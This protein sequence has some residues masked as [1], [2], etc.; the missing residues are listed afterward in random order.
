MGPI[1]GSAFDYN[2]AYDGS[3]DAGYNITAPGSAH[4]GSTASEMAHLFYNTLGNTGWY[5]TSGS[6]T[7]GCV[8]PDYCLTNTGPFTNLQPHY[9]WSGLEYAP[10]TYNAWYFGFNGGFQ[11][12]GNEYNFYYAWAVRPGDV[13]PV[14]AAVWLFGSGL[15]GLLGVGLRR[16][17]R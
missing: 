1:N 2:F 11:D 10:N 4:P 12:A 13:V 15:T 5:D 8:A 17:P 3:T 9:Y 6:N 7:T 16:R 14:P